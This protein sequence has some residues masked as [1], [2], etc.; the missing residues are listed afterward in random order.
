MDLDPLARL[1][2]IMRSFP[3]DLAYDLSRYVYEPGSHPYDWPAVEQGIGVVGLPSDYKRLLEG[4]GPLGVGGIFIV[5]PDHFA[6]RHDVHAASLRQFWSEFRPGSR[7]IHPDP[8]GLLYCAS[9]EG[10]DVLWWDTS[11]PD[12]DR[13]TIVWDVEFECHRFDG[14]LTELLVAELTGE[15]RPQLTDFTVSE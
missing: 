6:A 13:W 14:T 7:S 1:Q 9:T 4:Y 10:R 8:G 12:P 3:S 11:D 15:L 5:A 2:A